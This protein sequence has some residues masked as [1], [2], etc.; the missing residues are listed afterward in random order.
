[1][2]KLPERNT[3]TP[4]STSFLETVTNVNIYHNKQNWANGTKTLMQNL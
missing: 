2:Q 1:M 4:V 3:Y